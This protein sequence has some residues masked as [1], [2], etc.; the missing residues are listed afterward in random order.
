[1]KMRNVHTAATRESI[2]VSIDF[3]L[4]IAESMLF[5]CNIIQKNHT[6]GRRLLTLP[7]FE[8]I[9]PNVE[10]WKTSAPSVA[11]ACEITLS[12]CS[13]RIGRKPQNKTSPIGH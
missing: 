12:I 2:M 9:P 7:S 13:T 8:L 10:R 1:M 5:T 11:C 3:F 6:V 4:F